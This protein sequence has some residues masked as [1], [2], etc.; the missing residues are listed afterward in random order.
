[1][2]KIY[3]ML[4]AMFLS[5]AISGQAMAFSVSDLDFL[6]GIKGGT[7]EMVVDF[8]SS[9]TAKIVYNLFDATNVGATFD[10]ATGLSDLTAGGA[11]VLEKQV[12]RDQQRV[13]YF[14]VVSGATPTYVYGNFTNAYT[15]YTNIQAD[16]SGT[17]DFVTEPADSGHMSGLL[18]GTYNAF[19]SGDG[20]VNLGTLSALNPIAMDIWYFDNQTTYADQSDD[21]FE[22]TQYKLTFGMDGNNVYMQTSAVPI[23]GAF[24]LLA[25]GLFAMVGIRRKN[26]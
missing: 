1:M 5:V 26:K 20:S 8:D 10:G 25:S 24:F 6:G 12:G 18:S 22:R 17:G 9:I 16:Y 7:T 21:V 15:P 13:G 3:A 23:P 11:A 14:A 19:L 4:F 2:K